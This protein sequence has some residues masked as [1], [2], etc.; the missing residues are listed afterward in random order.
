MSIKMKRRLVVI[1]GVIVVVLVAVLAVVSATTTSKT[2][3]VA[4]AAQPEL[5]GSRVQVTGNVVDNSYSIQGNVLTFAIYDPDGDVATQLKVRYDGGVAATFGN[6]VTAI[7]TGTLDDTGVLDCIELV[8]K[9]P[10]KYESATDALTVSQLLDYG[11]SITG[12]PLKVTGSVKP[13][14]L[15]P[16]GQTDRL[17]LVDT[18]AGSELKVGFD[19]ALPD[20][21]V[22]DSILVVTGALD[23]SG[24]LKATDVALS[25]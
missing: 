1:T 25:S 19:G 17:V 18:A 3:T 15:K 4:E 10:S 22:D 13:G 6:Q 9:C 20:A 21:I 14:S 12:K 7:C 8:T 11:S 23:A 24:R 16:A 2:V 5:K